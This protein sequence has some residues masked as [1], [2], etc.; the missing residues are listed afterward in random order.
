MNRSTSSI[1]IAA[2][3][4]C[5]GLLTSAEYKL[6]WSDEFN[7][8]KLDTSIWSYENPVPPKTT[9]SNATPTETTTFT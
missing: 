3:V 7:G 6:V 5:L 9:N 4:L 2:I 1:I 8:N